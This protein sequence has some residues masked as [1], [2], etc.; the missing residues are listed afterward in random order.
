MQD[1]MTKANLILNEDALKHAYVTL[2]D[3]RSSQVSL[4]VSIDM[5]WESGLSF[6]V[7]LGETD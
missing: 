7:A 5:E 6:D 3:L 4:G 2:P 1:F